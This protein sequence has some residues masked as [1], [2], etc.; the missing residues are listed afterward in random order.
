MK[1]IVYRIALLL[2]LVIL[3]VLCYIKLNEQYDPLSRYPYVTEENKE[4]IL[5][6]MDDDDIDYMVNQQIKPDEYMDFIEIEGFDIH[7][8]RSY[9]IAK[10]TQEADLAYIVNFVNKYHTH[11]R[12]NELSTLLTHY[13]YLDLTTFYENEQLLNENVLLVS[14]PSDFKVLLTE[15]ESVYKYQPSNIVDM[16]DIQVSEKMVKDLEEMKMDY[17]TELSGQQLKLSQGYIPYD[18][19]GQIYAEKQV[20]YAKN[21]D[22]FYRNAG[23]SEY[24]LGYVIATENAQMWNEQCLSQ[25]NEENEEIDYTLV[26]E[27]LTPEQRNQIIWL[28]ENAYH[29]GFIVRYPLDKEEYTKQAY[30]PF[31]LR[32]VGKKQAKKMAKSQDCLEQIDMKG[33]KES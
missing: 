9:Q 16:D 15:N 25:L 5:K 4:V 21:T 22:L 28:E 6:Y 14:D 18:T 13:S 1:P 20:Q 29:Y 8:T 11:F 10:K 24:Q 19:L 23:Q 7:Q 27:S 26:E 30:Q 33:W 12:R 2:T 17:A 31:V 32:Y 3:F